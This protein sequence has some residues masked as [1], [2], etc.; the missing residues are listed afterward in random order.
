MTIP[1]L[2]A[3]LADARGILF[4]MDGVLIDSEPVHEKAIIALTAEL[5]DALD[6]EAVLYSF[7]GAPERSMAARL[8]EMYPDQPF[9]AAEIIRRKIDLFAGLFHHVRVIEGA[10]D[11]VERSH[12]A[13]RKHG[14]TTS[15]SRSTQQLA[16]ETFGFGKFFNTIVTGEDITLGKPHPEPYQLTAARLGLPAGDCLVIEDS[17]NGVLSGKAAGCRVIAITGTFPEEA[18]IEAGADYLIRS[19]EELR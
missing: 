11:F 10:E 7:K 4:D 1:S 2:S 15:A 19:F 14:L 6:D 13:G 5:G 9:T 3:S 17:I 16:F 12:S 8:L 18:L